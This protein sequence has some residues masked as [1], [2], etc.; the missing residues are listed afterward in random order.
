[1]S[2]EIDKVVKEM[3]TL[4]SFI[5]DGRLDHRG[6]AESFNGEWRRLIVGVNN[7]IDAFVAPINVTAECL[8][9]ITK[10]EIPEKI[11]ESYSGDFN[12]I[13]NNVNM[14]IDAMNEITRVTEE[15][16]AGNLMVDARERSENDRLMKALNSMIHGLMAAMTEMNDLTGRVRDGELAV[17]GDAGKF[18]GGWREL[19]EGVNSLIDA[20][21]EPINMTAD[22]IYRI[23]RGDIPDKITSVYKGD[24]DLIR[25]NLNKCID[26]VNA[27]VEETALLTE[28]AVDGKLST[29]GNL[30]NFDG[31][32]ARIVKGINDTLDAVIDPLTVAAEFIKRISIGDIPDVIAGEYRGD[33]NE[34][35]KSINMLISNLQAAVDVA[36]KIARGDLRV[37]VNILSD[38]DVLGKSLDGMVENLTRFTRNIQNSSVQVASGSEQ[39]S[40][41]AEQVSQ[42]TAHQAAS[43]QEIS[44]SMEEMNSTVDQNA[45]S[46]RQTAAIA[47]KAAQDAIE[48]GN[49]VAETV[50]AMESISE[51]IKIIEEIARQTNMLALNAAIEAA[52]AGDAGKG[53]A[54]VAAEVRSLAARSQRSAKEINFLSN[55]NLEIAEKA[56]G[57]LKEIVPQIQKTADLVEEINASSSEQARGI[58]QVNEAIQQ[59]DQGIQENAAS[60]EEMAS[61]SQDFSIQGE[62]LLQIA[63]FFKVSDDPPGNGG[64]FELDK[65]RS[66]EN[67]M[68]GMDPVSNTG[69][70]EKGIHIDMQDEIDESDFERY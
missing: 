36:E 29:R 64:N 54:V 42:G 50:T 37:K 28:S 18:E 66:L 26:T 35:K 45:D 7:L 2:S 52:R 32:Y 14:F 57:L 62:R 39:L 43:I 20:F 11:A 10:G 9:R 65:S 30:N 31:V 6:N 51:K 13:K 58:S 47:V 49:A 53:F 5:N 69:R 27:L 4:V 24:F 15:I 59:L 70:E 67:E 41:S 48:G 56:G 3:E 63:S 21:V 1:M 23:A 22:A 8:D 12:K 38:Q 17:R 40:S 16:A 33:F 44:A 25:N 34:I 68:I 46:A 61:S 19:I 55:T 60:T